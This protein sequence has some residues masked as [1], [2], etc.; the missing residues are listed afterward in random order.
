MPV[1]K[2]KAFTHRR[3]GGRLQRAEQGARKGA[4]TSW[5]AA[6]TTNAIYVESVYVYMD[7]MPPRMEILLRK[8]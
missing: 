3:W 5:E 7:Q 2:T 1:P 6:L 4:G 8:L